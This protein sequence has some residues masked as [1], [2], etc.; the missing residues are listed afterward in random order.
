ML[1]KTEMWLGEYSRA[2]QCKHEPQASVCTCSRI[3]PTTSRF[4]LACAKT[5]NVFYLFY[6][7]FYF[8]YRRF[9]HAG[10]YCSWLQIIVRVLLRRNVAATRNNSFIVLLFSNCFGVSCCRIFPFSV[11]FCK[12]FEKNVDSEK[13]VMTTR[14]DRYAI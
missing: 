14:V 9:L 13:K 12:R 1:M 11:I 7:L 3:L 5:V 10:F 6:K 2:G 4:S 8:F